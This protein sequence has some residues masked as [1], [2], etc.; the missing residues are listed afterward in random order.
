MA[1]LVKSENIALFEYPY[2]EE[3]DFD[4]DEKGVLFITGYKMFFGEREIGCA[5]RFDLQLVGYKI[6]GK[7]DEVVSNIKGDIS[8]LVKEIDTNNCLVMF[9]D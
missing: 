2:V 9:C 8:K 3:P 7:Y 4:L 6:F 1:I 5:K